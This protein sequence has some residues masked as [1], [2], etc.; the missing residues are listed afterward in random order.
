MS[1]VQSNS[2]VIPIH[3]LAL[4]KERE[5]LEDR[6]AR[7][8]KFMGTEQYKHQNEDERSL[9]ITQEHLMEEYRKVIVKRIRVA[10]Y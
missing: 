9:I 10:G 4:F 3:I 2:K 8:R 6:L 1:N 5:G 7:L